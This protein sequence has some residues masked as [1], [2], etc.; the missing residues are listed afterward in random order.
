MHQN[1]LKKSKFFN[2]WAIMQM[3]KEIKEGAKQA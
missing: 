1:N 3:E 2:R